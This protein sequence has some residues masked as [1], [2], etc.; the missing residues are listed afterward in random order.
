MIQQLIAK[1]AHK[2]LLILGF[3]LEGQSTYRFL[4]R[5]LADQ[6]LTIADQND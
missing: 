6:P 4:R 3:G 1:L 5:H 2:N